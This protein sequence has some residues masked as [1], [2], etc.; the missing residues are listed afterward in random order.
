M[1]LYL[2]GVPALLHNKILRCHVIYDAYFMS[3]STSSHLSYVCLFA[4]GIF[5]ESYKLVT[6]SLSTGLDKSIA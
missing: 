5:I 3:L 1:L 4:C 6:R 2:L